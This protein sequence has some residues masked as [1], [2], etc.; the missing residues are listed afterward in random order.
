M[1]EVRILYRFSVKPNVFRV[2]FDELTTANQNRDGTYS[3]WCYGC[4]RPTIVCN[5]RREIKARDCNCEWLPNQFCEARMVRKRITIYRKN[6]PKKI[7]V[8]QRKLK[9]IF[10]SFRKLGESPGAKI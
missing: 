2:S 4:N 1:M 6:L 7:S 9:N 8:I 3:T 5:E 10:Q